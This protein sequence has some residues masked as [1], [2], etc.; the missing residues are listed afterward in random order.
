MPELDELLSK[1]QSRDKDTIKAVLDELGDLGDKRAVP[2]LL[3]M[4][5]AGSDADLFESILWTLSRIADTTTLVELLKKSNEIIVIE[6]LDAL[7]RRVASD[8]VNDIIPFT[9]HHNAEVRA[10]AAWALGKIHADQTYDLLV[11]LLKNDED[12][13]V[14]ANAA[15]AIG[16]FQKIDTLPLL[17]NVKESEIDEAVL[18]NLDEAIELVQERK[19]LKSQGLK[20]TVYECQNRN[21]HCSQKKTQTESILDNFIEVKVIMCDS[22]KIAKVCQVN[23]IRKFL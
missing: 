11:N 5:D 2:Q 19:D 17:R 6:L 21:D 8:A 1:L 13:L 23:L 14:R 3:K 18:Y 22:C 15:W 16:K 20:E 12:P 10:I 4:L 7:G 9:K